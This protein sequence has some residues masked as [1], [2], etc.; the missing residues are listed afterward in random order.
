MPCCGKKRTQARR[1]TQTG[2]APEPAEKAVSQP[3]PVRDS[4]PRFQYL[5]KTGLTVIGP[6][7]G[8]RY[9]FD[10][11]GAVVTVDPRDWRSLAAVSVLKQVRASANVARQSRVLE[12][13]ASRA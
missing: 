3:N 9:R 6:R 12:E 11:P 10:R 4:A 2:R 8:R 13:S 5:G 7:T 1:E